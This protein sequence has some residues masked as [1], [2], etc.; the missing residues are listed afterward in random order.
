M[1]AP[2]EWGHFISNK[3][4]EPAREHSHETQNAFRKLRTM[5]FYSRIMQPNQTDIITEADIKTLVD[6][7]YQK[8]NA[9]ELLSPIF[10]G[11]AQVDW[12]EHLPTMY[13]FWGSMLLRTN[14]YRGR[15]W[16]KHALLPVNAAHFTR[17]LALFKQTV[18]ERFTG[19]KAIE[20]KNIA[21]SIAD[22]FQNRLQLAR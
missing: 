3:S 18:D 22:T 20:A 1:S 11:V 4:I 7:F 2:A 9:D 10:N 14:N 17:W 16:P 8:V 15:P 13:Q 6:S 12:A 5:L 19:L 21:A